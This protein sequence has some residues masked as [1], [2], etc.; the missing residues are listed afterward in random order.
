MDQAAVIV[1]CG[2]TKFSS[3][4]SWPKIFNLGFRLLRLCSGS[5]YS[6]RCIMLNCLRRH[7]VLRMTIPCHV[8]F[9]AT[10]HSKSSNF[11]F[12]LLHSLRS[13]TFS[14]EFHWLGSLGDPRSASTDCSL[15]R[16]FLPFCCCGVGRRLPRGA[17]SWRRSM[18]TFVR[19][20][21]DFDRCTD[22]VIPDLRFSCQLTVHP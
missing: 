20:C 3:N 12:K 6:W 17:I 5:T 19:N 10:S 1:A 16:L 13:S 9:L 4:Q 7:L 21:V 11:P 2:P 8:A 22:K 14:I 18:L 15:P